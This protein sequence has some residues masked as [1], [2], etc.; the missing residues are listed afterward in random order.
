M[1]DWWSRKLTGNA[2]ATPVRTFSTPVSTPPIGIRQNTMAVTPL[3]SQDVAQQQVLDEGRSATDQIGMSDAIRLWKGG[4]AHR[5]DGNSSCP[6]CGSGLVF[7][8]TGRSG[9]T[10]NGN[11][12]A[13]R[14]FSC[15][16]NG[17]YEQADQISWSA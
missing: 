14:C 5:R 17:M 9:T 13:P 8:R 7:S 16:W 3:H 15:G 6:S 4:E 11:A 1:S 12:P 10:V 2:P